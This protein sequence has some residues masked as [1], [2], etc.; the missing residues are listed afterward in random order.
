MLRRDRSSLKSSSPSIRYSL[1]TASPPHSFDSV[2]LL[3]VTPIVQHVGGRRSCV[4]VMDEGDMR[5]EAVNGI[6]SAVIYWFESRVVCSCCGTCRNRYRLAGARSDD[7]VLKG[8]DSASEVLKNFEENCHVTSPADL[9][10]LLEEAREASQ[11]I[12]TI[13]VQAKLNK[14]GGYV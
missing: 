7:S 11:F 6:G 5:L 10:H 2:F 12:S 13:I 8:Y 4:V 9:S 1:T 3:G 14:R